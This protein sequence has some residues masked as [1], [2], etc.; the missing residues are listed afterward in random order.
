MYVLVFGYI[1]L[2]YC[3]ADEMNLHID[4]TERDLKKAVEAKQVQL[5]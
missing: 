5:R 1:I 2:L 3:T 4:T